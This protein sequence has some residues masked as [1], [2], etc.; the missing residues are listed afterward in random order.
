[1]LVL[2][3]VVVRIAKGR[4]LEGDPLFVIDSRLLFWCV[5]LT[6]VD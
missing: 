2:R 1:M 5:N 3:W 4:L 6:L